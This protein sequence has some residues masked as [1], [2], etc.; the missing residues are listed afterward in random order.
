M[1][2]L[3]DVQ[4][5]LGL[6]FPSKEDDEINYDTWS[7]ELIVYSQGRLLVSENTINQQTKPNALIIRNTGQQSD[8]LRHRVVQV[9]ASYLKLSPY[10][11]NQEVTITINDE[12][13][14]DGKWSG[15]SNPY[16]L[17]GGTQEGSFPYNPVLNV[18]VNIKDY[19]YNEDTLYTGL[20]YSFSVPSSNSVGNMS[21]INV[22]VG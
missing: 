10:T 9:D 5:L 13:Q 8:N 21:S 15:V 1:T 18:V 17:W 7:S 6:W 20:R 12:I 19:V 4:T 3:E 11:A 22:V 16:I 14:Y 2:L